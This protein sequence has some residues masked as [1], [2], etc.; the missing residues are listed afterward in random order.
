MSRVADKVAFISGG[1]RGMGAA[2]ARALVAEGAKV[3]IGD[4]LDTE[5]EQ[6][7]ASSGGLVQFVHLD[8]TS[9]QSWADA[10]TATL[11]AFGR[12]DV[13]VNNAGIA[14]GNPLAQF[15]LSD[16][17]QILDINLTGTFLGMQAV[18]E[19][20]TAA[21]SGSIINISSVSGLRGS[22]GRY[23]YTATKFAVR[24][25]T[26]DAAL[27]LG[28]RGIRVNSVHPGFTRTG[29][30]TGYP[31]D[32]EQIPLRRMA[33]PQDISA[34]VVYLASEESSYSTGCEFVIDGGLTAGI[35]YRSPG[36]Y[37]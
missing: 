21:G 25:I 33:E 2:H 11:G 27:E 9:P 30:T 17:Q 4:V 1:A 12:L 22:A 36:S 29:M 31:I 34:C 37:T 15:P 35:A 7:A 5:G 20:M 18:V 24:G 23:G 13:L 3:V 8:V 14:N 26:K 19:P 10:V 32:T 16:W 28:P 6:L